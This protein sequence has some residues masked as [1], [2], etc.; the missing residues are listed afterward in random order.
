[1]PPAFVGHINHL[2]A[3]F[4]RGKINM[5]LHFVSLLHIDMTQ[6]LKPSSSKTSTYIFY[7]V[8]II[9]A[10]VLVT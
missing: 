3:K 1:M 7:T 6:V 4:F 8:N 5:Y 9:A 10:D 2:R